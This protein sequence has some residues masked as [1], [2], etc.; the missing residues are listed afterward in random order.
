MP[1][2]EDLFYELR[3]KI[4]ALAKSEVKEYADEAVEDGKELLHQS[5][6]KL[7]EWTLALTDGMIDKELFAWLVDSQFKLIEMKVLTQT[8]ITQIKIEKFKDSV[9][10]LVVDTILSKVLKV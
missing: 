8:G 10:H 2:F 3:D 1:F 6:V 9:R 7:K 4:A 5:K